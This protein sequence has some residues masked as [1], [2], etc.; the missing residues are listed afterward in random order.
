MNKSD[1]YHYRDSWKSYNYTDRNTEMK[2]WINVQK[3][4]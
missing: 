2:P 1:N 3:L 4:K